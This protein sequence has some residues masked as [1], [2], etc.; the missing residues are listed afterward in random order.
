MVHE[1]REQLHKSREQLSEQ[2]RE[3]REQLSEQL[4]ESREQL[5]ESR[6]QLHEAREQARM[7]RKLLMMAVVGAVVAVLVAVRSAGPG[8]MSPGAPAAVPPIVEPEAALS[9]AP[10]AVPT[11][12]TSAA[13]PVAPAVTT[14][15]DRAVDDGGSNMLSGLPDLLDS[16][17]RPPIHRQQ[18]RG[19]QQEIGPL[20]A[21]G[22]PQPEARRA[23]RQ[24]ALPPELE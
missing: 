4:R 11:I 3:S 20:R 7:E 13:L 15:D 16:G 21:R 18:L 17:D 19:R 5:R 12:E 8:P 24:P 1:L 6:E 9:L 10:A 14:S 2:R 22:R 23:A